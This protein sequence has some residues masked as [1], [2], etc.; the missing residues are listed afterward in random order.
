MTNVELDQAVMRVANLLKRVRLSKGM[1]QDEMAERVGVSRKTLLRY[2]T[3]QTT[4][5][6]ETLL[7]IA[8]AAGYTLDVRLASKTK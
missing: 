3:G 6:L 4:P 7:K 8:A 2:E 5:T 1:T